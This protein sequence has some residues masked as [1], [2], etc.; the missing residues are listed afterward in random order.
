MNVKY[1]YL[2]NNFDGIHISCAYMYLWHNCMQVHQ[3]VNCISIVSR[4]SPNAVHSCPL[5]PMD[6]P[7][8]IES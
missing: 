2:S 7:L 1:K 3:G 6:S 5:P 4:A 8:I